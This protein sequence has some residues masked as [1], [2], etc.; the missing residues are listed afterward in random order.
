MKICVSHV[1]QVAFLVTL[2]GLPCATF[3]TTTGDARHHHGSAFPDY[4]CVLKDEVVRRL[5]EREL[6]LPDHVRLW[7]LQKL[8]NVNNIFYLQSTTGDLVNVTHQS[9]QGISPFVKMLLDNAWFYNRHREDPFAMFFYREAP[10][11]PGHDIDTRLLMA[12]YQSDMVG[13]RDERRV[14]VPNC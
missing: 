13:S 12:F 10:T 6:S 8:V 5:V 2:C 7:P 14:V 1:Q 11:M 4:Q 3:T 9:H